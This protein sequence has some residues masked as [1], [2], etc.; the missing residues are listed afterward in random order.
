MRLDHVTIL[1]SDVEASARFFREALGL[2]AGPRP[3]FSFDGAWL[4]A[5]G[6]AVVHLKAPNQLPADAA[7]PLE[8]VAFKTEDFDGAVARLDAMG[9]ECR[10]GRLPD[11]S[12]RQC[13][14]R[15]ANGA[16]I[17]IAGA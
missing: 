16:V 7:G 17:E 15:D 2:E 14:F 6:T 8:H 13:F 5:G 1:T 4:Y 9:V 3:A 11:G 10:L 12:L